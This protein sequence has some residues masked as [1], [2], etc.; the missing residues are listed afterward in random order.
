MEQFKKSIAWIVL[1]TFLTALPSIAQAEEVDAEDDGEGDYVEL[2]AEE[3]APFDG[4]LL[5]KN[6]MIKL[7]TERESEIGRIKLSFETTQKKLQL[8]LETIT[9][10]KDIEIQINKEMY[11]QL[12]KIRQDRIDSLSSEQKWNNAKLVGG[13]FAGLVIGF[14]VTVGIVEATTAILK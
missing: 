4:F 14:A 2:K 9:R 1:S 7:V 12:L 8:D 6:A 3:A 11:E 13:V 5:H 10:K